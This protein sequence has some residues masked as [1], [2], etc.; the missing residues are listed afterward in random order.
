M[1]RIPLWVC[2]IVLSSA[3]FCLARNQYVVRHIH[4][5][6]FTRTLRTFT[7]LRATYVEVRESSFLLFISRLASMRW[8]LTLRTSCSLCIFADTYPPLRHRAT[9]SMYSNS[10]KESSFLWGQSNR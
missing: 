4:N 3:P 10:F 1:G 6:D 9:V 5:R 8:P 2:P 7:L